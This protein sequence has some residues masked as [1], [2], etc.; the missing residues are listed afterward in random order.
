MTNAAFKLSHSEAS[1]LVGAVTDVRGAEIL[2]DTDRGELCAERAASCLLAA[3]AGDEVG[4]LTTGDGRAFVVAVLVKARSE[5]TEIAV[6]GDLRISARGGSCRIDARDGVE[7]SSEG[8]VSLSSRILGIRAVEGSVV[9]SSLTLLAS[10]VLAHTDGARVAA[11]AF[12]WVCD[13]FSSTVTRSHR[14]VE[15]LDEVR[16]GRIDYRT[17]NE[18]CLRSENFLVGARQLAKLDAEQIHIG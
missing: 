15:D 8:A 3:A 18:M 14:K 6:N 5:G 7:L 4:V 10:S 2:V 16:A 9:L 17:E 11:K 12:D 13:R 1:Y